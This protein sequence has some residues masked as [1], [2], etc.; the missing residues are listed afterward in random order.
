MGKRISFRAVRPGPGYPAAGQLTA[1][2]TDF[3]AEHAR[4][5]GFATL[6]S[7]AGGREWLV[8]LHRTGTEG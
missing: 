5:I 6:E 8:R 7:V 1:L 4:L 2:T 3:S